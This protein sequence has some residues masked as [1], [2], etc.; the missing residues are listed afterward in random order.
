MIW[1]I[2]VQTIIVLLSV[3]FGYGLGAGRRNQ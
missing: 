2:I 3:A 1:V